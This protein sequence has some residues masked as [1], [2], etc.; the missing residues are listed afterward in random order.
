MTTRTLSVAVLGLALLGAAMTGWWLGWSGLGVR[1]SPGLA[2][3]GTAGPTPAATSGDEL[4]ATFCATCHGESGRGDGIAAGFTRT[5]P[6]DLTRAEFKVR[7]TPLN[8]LP[9]DADLAAVIGRGAGGVGGMPAFGFLIDEEVGRLVARIKAFSPRWQR[10]QAPP[11]VG[12]PPHA[13]GEI[14]R[15]ERV[16]RESDCADCHGAKGQGDGPRASGLLTSRGLVDRPTD[17]TRPWTFKAGADEAGLVRSTLTGFSGTTMPAYADRT[18]V[19]RQIWDLAAYLRFLQVP[20]PNVDVAAV[21]TS[22]VDAY[23]HVPV[24]PQ[25]GDLSSAYCSTCHAAQFRDWSGTRHSMAMGPGVYAQMDDNPAQSGMCATCHSPLQDQWT[26]SYLSADGVGCAGCHA[27]GRE[28]FGPMPRPTSIAPLVANFPAPHGP[29]RARGFFEE[30]EFCARCHQ[31]REGEAPVVHGSVLQ[32]TVEEW[33][34][35]RAAR[36]GKT[37]QSCHMPDRRHLFKGIHDPDTVRAGVSWAF[38]ARRTDRGLESRMT[39][40]NTGTGHA[41]PTYVVP[42]VWMR[43]DLVLAD[44]AIRLA[45][46]RLIARQVAFANGAWTQSADTRLRQDETATLDYVGAVPPGAIAIVGSIIVRPDAYHVRSL[47]VRLRETTSERSRQAYAQAL[48]E[49]RSSE[50]VLFRD[51]RRLQP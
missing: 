35:S 38:E 47:G 8:A 1:R 27:R 42:E 49:M 43:I 25:G 28:I 24:P 34:G 44:G 33:R 16:Y 14:A 9:T 40:T 7:S 10:E 26:D 37:C 21:D 51:G 3:A 41:F 30:V 11:A 23:W 22:G 39:L 13:T 29:A 20:G 48:A 15:G 4:F 50:Y 46:E 17:L 32:N 36:E 12:I 45:A 19:A 2:G 6:T 18:D 31:F 5:P